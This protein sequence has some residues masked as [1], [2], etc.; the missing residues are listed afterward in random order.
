MMHK[1]VYIFYILLIT[2]ILVLGCAEEETTEPNEDNLLY[3]TSF[4]SNGS[5]STD[6]WTISAASKSSNSTPPGGGSYSL[7]INATD[8]PEVFSTFRVAAKTQYSINRLE[9]WSKASGVSSNV[10]GKAVLSL[11]RNGAELQSS[12]ISIDRI[13]WGTF[14][15]Q[16]TFAVAAGDS[17]L[18]KL[19]GGMNQ[20]LSG[21]TYFD[22]IQLQGIK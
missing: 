12:S 18:V 19:S 16:D 4:E 2:T 15:L 8:P 6:G 9:F 3:E 11:V 5:F 7:E 22:L 10:Y 1:T 14:T 17:F 21:K 20:L 13:D